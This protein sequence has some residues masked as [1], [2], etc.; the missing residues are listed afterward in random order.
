MTTDNLVSTVQQW[1][2]HVG[3]VP[4]VT[5]AVVAGVAALV[6]VAGLLRYFGRGDSAKKVT[7]VATVLGLAWSAQGMADTA[8][9]TYGQPTVVAAVLF[10]V[11]E[12]WLVGR[13]LRAHQY[14]K[15]YRRRGRFVQ[16]VWVGAVV[17]AFVVA[18]GEGWSQA[19]GRLAI[20][21]LVT[22]GWYTDLT[23]D[24]DPDEKPVTSVRWTL[25]RALLA[26]GAIEPGKRDAVTIDRD[27]L[28]DR[29]TR[30]AFRMRYG[31]PA[32][33]NLLRRK[34]RLAKLKTVADD[35]DLTE[36]RARLARMDVALTVEPEPAR[37]EQPA[38]EI[39]PVPPPQPKPK[40][41]VS[42]AK[43]AEGDRLPQG[44]HRRLG[45]TLRGTDLHDDAVAVMLKSAT[46]ERPGGMTTIELMSLYDPPLK[47]RKA[48]EFAAAARRQMRTQRVNGSTP[49][50]ADL[51]K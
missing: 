20:P 21:L 4:V 13:M 34:V 12:A 37:R 2:D 27:R 3:G 45:R 30:L 43:P 31:S 11:F 51:P 26:I 39:H 29:M 1:I 38:P 25:R 19:P 5:V 16:A 44:V 35:T 28:R 40:E 14:R 17:M 33:N 24:D 41:V 10:I 42:P 46:P 23:A 47:Q 22:Y 36:V 7:A 6:A 49:D 32:V 48:D 18:T 8:V 15:D 50:L 9:N